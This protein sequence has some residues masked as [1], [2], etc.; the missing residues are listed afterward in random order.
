MKKKICLLFVLILCFLLVGCATTMEEVKLRSEKDCYTYLRNKNDRQKI[1]KVSEDIEDYS[2][3]YW[4]Q[5]RKTGVEYF[6]RTYVKKNE[7]NL[8][9]SGGVWYTE[10]IETNY[11]DAIN[12][13]FKD[14]SISD[15]I[16]L[17]NK[18]NVEFEN[19]EKYAQRLGIVSSLSYDSKFSF[20]KIFYKEDKGIKNGEDCVKEVSDLLNKVDDRHYFR[21]AFV[22]IYRR[23]ETI[24][25]EDIESG[26]EYKDYLE[27]YY[28]AKD[29]KYIT[30]EE[31]KVQYYLNILNR[32]LMDN[33]LCNVSSSQL[34]K[35]MKY[36][37]RERIP[38]EEVPTYFGL[39]EFDDYAKVFYTEET[40][41]GIE[42]YHFNV[43][44]Q[45]WTVSDVNIP[46]FE[47]EHSLGIT[48]KRIK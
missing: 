17:K 23:E 16:E 36:L 7:F 43:N 1:V 41:S 8:D 14:I 44:N 5:E 25:V 37:N 26:L 34:L 4:Y 28:S 9:G 47:K 42:I 30:E 12:K 46:K 13:Y 40:Y 29:K 19:N 10:E 3:K 21:T 2:H 32:Y 39:N 31:Y 24:N 20:Y 18:Y 33:K 48:I 45:E 27:G 6:V 15:M 11:F 38:L 22:P 35:Y